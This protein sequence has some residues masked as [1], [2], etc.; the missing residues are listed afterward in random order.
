M[1]S[2]SNM[3]GKPIRSLEKIMAEVYVEYNVPSDQIATDLGHRA[4]FTD[5]L[6]Q[7]IADEFTPENVAKTLMN[8]RKASKLPRIRQTA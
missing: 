1:L 2:S 4:K 8:Q 3:L 7:R 5:L 6:R